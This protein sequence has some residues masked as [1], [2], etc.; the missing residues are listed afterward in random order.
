MIL[1]NSFGKNKG[2]KY[3][4]RGKHDQNPDILYAE[5]A[6]TF[7]T[8]FGQNYNTLLQT[9]KD[10]YIFDVFMKTSCFAE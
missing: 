10:K 2:K 5:K 3:F 8:W 9:L 6:E 1:G 7:N 4:I